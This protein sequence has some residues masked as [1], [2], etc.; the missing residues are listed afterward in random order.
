MGAQAVLSEKAN[1]YTQNK[2]TAE[3]FERY[4]KSSSGFALWFKLV[5]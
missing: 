5:L 1:P 4:L 2:A 3:D